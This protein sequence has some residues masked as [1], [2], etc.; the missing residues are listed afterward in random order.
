MCSAD[1]YLQCF[2]HKQ[3]DSTC[4]F[5]G[6][7][8]KWCNLG[9]LGT[10][11]FYDLPSTTHGTY[12]YRCITS[13][14]NPVRHVSDVRNYATGNQGR[15]NNSHY[16]LCVITTVTNTKR[17]RRD[18]LQTFKPLI[19]A[20]CIKGTEKKSKNCHRCNDSTEQEPFKILTQHQYPEKF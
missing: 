4:S 10:H 20:V 13:Y 12:T 1:W 19:R 3:G 18:Q 16:F 8:F 11:R 17:S 6:Y 14:W 2:S 15:C 7:T 5:R 9:D